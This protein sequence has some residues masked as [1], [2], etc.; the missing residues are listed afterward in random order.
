LTIFLYH[1]IIYGIVYKPILS[2]GNSMK[3]LCLANMKGGVGKTTISVTLAANLARHGKTCLL[4]F[5]PQ[6][7][8][9]T[10]AVPDN[11]NPSV[12][13]A[14]VLAGKIKPETAVI[15]ANATGL[16]LLPTFGIG[17]GLKTYIENAGELQINKAVR[18]ALTGIAAQG[19]RWTVIDLSP[20]FGK[21]ER[22]ALI[23]ATEAIT[24]ILCDRFCID[25]LEAITANIQNLQ[26]LIDKP[27]AEYRRIIINGVDR[28]IKRHSE[29][30]AS[31]KA[32]A[33]QAVYTLPIDQV[34]FRA[35]AASE[36]IWT[37]DPKPETTAEIERLT[38]DLIGGKA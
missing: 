7:S 33:K 2:K 13:L 16:Y 34:F 15:P 11:V 35:Q 12:E 20:A 22:A 26:S 29:I 31:I 9:S 10:W 38:N 28:R 4:D 24:P 14:D 3:T 19:Y 27:I 21:L 18:E 6:G 25:G 23:A 17:G 30:S 1:S 8:A 36:M 5:D 32:G 37:L